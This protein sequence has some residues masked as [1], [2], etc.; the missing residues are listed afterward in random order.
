MESG[1][2]RNG[3]LACADEAERNAVRRPVERAGEQRAAE[4]E[5]REEPVAAERPPEQTE[6]RAE[7][8]EEDE[9]LEDVANGEEHAGLRLGLGAVVVL[10]VAKTARRPVVLRRIA[11][12]G[13]VQRGD[14]L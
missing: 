14:V 5:D 11:T 7:A 10:V 2:L 9:R 3:E 8:D 1:R 12:A 6:Q 13:A 4:D